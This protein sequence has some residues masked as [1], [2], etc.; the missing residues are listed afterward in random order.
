MNTITIELCTEDR[1]RLDAILTALESRPSCER[2]AETVAEMYTDATQAAVFAVDEKPVAVS[3]DDI[4]QRV[5][6]LLAAGKKAE[7]RT[8]I[9][10]YAETVSSIP[11]D[12]RGGFTEAD[13]V[14]G[15]RYGE[16][17]R[18]QQP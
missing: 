1:A 15:L 4:Q 2:C 17:E 3:Q 10:A 5:S 11:E 14:G 16:F 18:P 13:R 9:K 8:V 12:K 6:E 7:I